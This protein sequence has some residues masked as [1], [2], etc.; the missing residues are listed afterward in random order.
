MLATFL[1]LTLLLASLL[2]LLFPS[3]RVRLALA[4]LT[5]EHTAVEALSYAALRRA[6]V[7]DCTPP[8]AIE[9]EIDEVDRVLAAH[10]RELQQARAWGCVAALMRHRDHLSRLLVEWRSLARSRS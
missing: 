2:L 1:L 6:L 8:K 4:L 3:L 10:G 5:S 7:R 9:Y